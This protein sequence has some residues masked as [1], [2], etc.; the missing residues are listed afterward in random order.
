M[1]NLNPYGSGY[2]VAGGSPKAQGV[3]TPHLQSLD[4]AQI[5]TP[6]RAESFDIMGWGILL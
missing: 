6:A 5:V 4:A 2:E 1:E 3:D